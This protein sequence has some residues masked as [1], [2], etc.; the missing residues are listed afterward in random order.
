MNDLSVKTYDCGTCCG[1]NV[2]CPDFINDSCPFS[3]NAPKAIPH[4]ARKQ[5]VQA[6][7]DPVG[8]VLREEVKKRYYVP[9]QVDVLYAW[10]DEEGEVRLIL[11]G[12]ESDIEKWRSNFI[13]RTQCSV[14]SIEVLASGEKADPA[15]IR[16]NIR[17]TGRGILTMGAL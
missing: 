3:L 14:Y 15:K 8:V 4:S 2:S 6:V 7:V 16:P 1:D 17:K 13:R 10:R 9:E 12:L 11:Y 5:I